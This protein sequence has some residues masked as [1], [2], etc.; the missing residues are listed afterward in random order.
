M[1]ITPGAFNHAFSTAFEVYTAGIDTRPF[2]GSC[3]WDA[4]AR[5]AN[6]DVLCDSCGADL[7]RFGFLFQE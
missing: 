3:G 6:D 2:C 4:E 7:R 1:T 5:N